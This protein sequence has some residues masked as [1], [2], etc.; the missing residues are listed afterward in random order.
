[1][2]ISPTFTLVCALA[3]FGFR[4]GFIALGNVDTA[5]PAPESVE[6]GHDDAAYARA[7]QA[8]DDA[9]LVANTD[10]EQG[11]ALLNRALSALHQFAPLLARDDEARMRRS[12]AHLALARA[13]LARGDEQGAAESVDST[14]RELGELELPIDQLGPTL[15]QL[16]EDRR[17]ALA[18]L[19]EA[20]LRVSCA[21]DCTVWIDERLAD[22]TLMSEGQSLVLGSHRIWIEDRTAALEP[23]RTSVE[24]RSSDSP[25]ELQYPAPEVPP[26]GLS[27]DQ[28][29]SNV[30]GP[31]RNRSNRIAPRWAEVMATSVG[32]AALAVGATLWAIDDTCPGGA[33]PMDI[34][35][36]PQLYDTRDAGIT[37][38]VL[39]AATMVTGVVLLTID[40]HRQRRRN[41]GMGR[42][43]V[44]P[45]GLRF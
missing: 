35:A 41:R 15:G 4:P 44:E 25:L 36:C 6:T 40:E 30:D 19:G 31:T 5:S 34:V 2:G 32:V 22:P 43:R 10:P 17:A 12:L 38:V 29:N 14:L 37:T 3:V 24:L 13:K 16:L 18:A 45:M 8:L 20:R 23:L 9:M 21:V 27:S 11:I 39:G 7:L 33:D 26:P 28:A 42:V 1:M